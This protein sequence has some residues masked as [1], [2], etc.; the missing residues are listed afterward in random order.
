MLTES[1]LTI[2]NK[3]KKTSPFCQ[4]QFS[5]RVLGSIQSPS[6]ANLMNA[7]HVLKDMLQFPVCFNLIGSSSPASIEPSQLTKILQCP[8]CVKSLQRPGVP[9]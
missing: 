5:C 1:L 4:S 9:I 8:D 7:L 3:F 2:F 6:V